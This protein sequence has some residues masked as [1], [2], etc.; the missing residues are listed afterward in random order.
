VKKR[1]DRRGEEGTGLQKEDGKREK[2]VAD[3]EKDWQENN[4]QVSPVRTPWIKEPRGG[5][6]LKKVQRKGNSRKTQTPSFY[7]GKIGAKERP[8]F[9]H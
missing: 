9:S 2:V 7:L 8:L 4:R 6:S 5:E 1:G 3:I